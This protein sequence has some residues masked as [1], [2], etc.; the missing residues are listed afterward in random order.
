MHTPRSLKKKK[1]SDFAEGLLGVSVSVRAPNSLRMC[2]KNIGANRFKSLKGLAFSTA[3]SELDWM[4][5]LSTRRE[6]G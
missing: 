1:K 3:P 6:S 4:S 2:P 5:S